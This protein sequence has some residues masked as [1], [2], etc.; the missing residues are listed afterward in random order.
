[1]RKNRVTLDDQ[2]IGKEPFFNPGETPTEE[3]PRGSAWHKAMYYY[4]YHY[5]PKNYVPYCIK[6]AEEV[7]GYNKKD[8]QALKKLKDWQFLKVKSCILH[9][10]GWEHNEK[11]M[12]YF[13]PLFEELV[14]KAK[15][16][17]EEKKE[18]QKNKPAPISPVERTRRKILDTAYGD[19]QEFV[20]DQWIEGNYKVKFDMYTRFKM[21]GLKSNAINMIKDMIQPEYDEL[22]DAYNKTC[23]QA[24]EAYSHVTKSELKSMMKTLD[25]IF[26]DLERLRDSFKAKRMPRAKKPKASDR[27]V[28][29]LKYLQEDMDS[30]LTSINPI[31]I[32]G[33][34]KLFVY[35]V[36]QRKLMEY[37]TD[38][39]SGFEVR[40]STITNFTNGRSCTLRKPEEILPQII[41][42]TEKQIENVWNGITT[43]ITKPTGR[44]NSDCIL[45]RVI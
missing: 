16:I 14:Q 41:Q 36:K 31:L 4:N 11:D 45:M 2:Y 10:R 23:D 27:Q 20:I 26:S 1:M 6:F 15:L 35:N 32:P 29:K 9:F 7:L 19:F 21:G 25:E 13:V 40:G 18:E 28:E 24:V 38:S 8:I 17:I 33:K 12:E 22:N 39:V 44:I 37:T 34:H 43:K 5:K 42:K 30:K 3:S